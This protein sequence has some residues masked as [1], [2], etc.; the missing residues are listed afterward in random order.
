MRMINSL[1]RLLRGRSLTIKRESLAKWARHHNVTSHYARIR[2]FPKHNRAHRHG[3]GGYFHKV[4]VEKAET[5]MKR[6]RRLVV[7]VKKSKQQ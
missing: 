6:L 7:K 1:K 2:R 4:R 5:I 3:W